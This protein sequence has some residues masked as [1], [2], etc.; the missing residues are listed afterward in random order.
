MSFAIPLPF[1]SHSFTSTRN[2]EYI[3]IMSN[4]PTRAHVASPKSSPQTP[5]ADLEIPQTSSPEPELSDADSAIA[6]TTPT[7]P[8]SRKEKRQLKKA[9]NDCADSP[10]ATQS[11]KPPNNPPKKYQ[12]STPASMPPA[13]SA[14]Q[15]AYP[16]L[17]CSIGNPGSTYANTLH[18]A[19]HILTS[20]LAVHK[21]YKPFTKGLAGQ[22]S[23]PDTSGMSFGIFSGFQRT[24]GAPITVA[25]DW[26]FWQST[27]LMNVSGKG[28]GRAYNEW[29]KDVKRKYGDPA[30]EGRL[31][32][33]HDELE[34]QLGKVTV[35][36]GT[37][38]AKGHNG[39]KSCQASLGKTKW[40]RV[41]VGI[42]RPDSREPDVVAKYVL[43][44]MS[45]REKSALENSAVGVFK[46]LEEIAAGQK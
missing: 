40:W 43:K 8:L 2:F 44:K 20:Y 11:S 17:V 30:I 41:G 24:D 5:A 33:V 38:S 27:S 9:K 46:A 4:A 37:A 26:T 6:F 13:K 31:V 34:S 42:G 7:I 15:T 28:V 22:V 36:D 45:P 14:I 18:S 29:L 35:R 10:P 19:G 25:Q 1:L 12:L 32:V 3:L 16:L 23:T 21:S 39:L